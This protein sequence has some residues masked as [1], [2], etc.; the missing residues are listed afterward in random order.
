MTVIFGCHLDW[1]VWLAFCVVVYVYLVSLLRYQRALYIQRKFNKATGAPY[2][3]MTTD[4]AHVIMKDLTEL[5]FPKVF[6]FSIIFAVFKAC[7]M[8]FASDSDC[9]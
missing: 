1:K 9:I 7:D 4:E 8:P 6:G 3:K 5:E 2:Y